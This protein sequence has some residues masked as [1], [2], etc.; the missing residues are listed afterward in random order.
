MKNVRL[1]AD[2]LAQGLA[3]A[4]PD[5]GQL[6]VVRDD[7]QTLSRLYRASAELRAVSRNPTIP[8]PTK[9]RAIGAV[10]QKLGA[11]AI[12]QKLLGVLANAD[13]L[14]LLPEVSG[15]VGRVLDRRVGVH[16]AVVTTALP[17]DET[18]RRRLVAS[19]EKMTGGTIRLEEKVDPALL[20]G[21]VVEVAGKVLDGTLRSKLDRMLQRMTTGAAG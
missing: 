3:D 7:L 9:A 8:P 16:Q 12:T 13:Q 2:R 4:V 15:A 18:I 14:T 17:L 1:I 10:A 20:G 5:N 19:L 21:V 6:A 11:S